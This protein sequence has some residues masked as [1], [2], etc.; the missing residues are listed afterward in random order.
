MR[1]VTESPDRNEY[2]LEERRKEARNVLFFMR[3]RMANQPP[4]AEQEVL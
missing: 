3:L 1:E 2:R 4:A